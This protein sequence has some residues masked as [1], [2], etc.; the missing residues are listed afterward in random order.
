MKQKLQN[1]TTLLQLHHNNLIQTPKKPKQNARCP[2]PPE[3]KEGLSVTRP[4]SLSSRARTPVLSV[5]SFTLTAGRGCVVVK[6]PWV[7]QLRTH[8]HTNTIHVFDDRLLCTFYT[9]FHASHTHKK[10]TKSTPRITSRGSRASQT[11]PIE[12]LTYSFLQ[13]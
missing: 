13:V 6:S 7:P 4:S 1:K 12:M 3:R 10:N 5:K 8:I 9:H 2:K 11:T